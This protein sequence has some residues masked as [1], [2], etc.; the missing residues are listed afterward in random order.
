MEYESVSAQYRSMAKK[1]RR[2]RYDYERRARHRAVR[3]KTTEPAENAGLFGI[4]LFTCFALTAAAFFISENDSPYLSSI[5]AKAAQIVETNASIDD[6]RGLWQK[7]EV[8]SNPHAVEVDEKLIKEM[9]ALEP[10]N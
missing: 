9:E 1:R 7:T 6:I 3:N 8:L 4:R 10:K 5:S 2:S